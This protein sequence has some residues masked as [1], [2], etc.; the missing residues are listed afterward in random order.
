MSRSR[1]YF[2]SPCHSFSV[3]FASSIALLTTMLIVMQPPMHLTKYCSNLTRSDIYLAST[4]INSTKY[5][6]LV[7]FLILFP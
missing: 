7:I 5:I 2:T 4:V 6:Y 1:G 3:W